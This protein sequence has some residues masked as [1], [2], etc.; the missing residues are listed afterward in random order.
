MAFIP[1]FILEQYN[2]NKKWFVNWES[3]SVLK[4][5]FIAL[6]TL[7]FKTQCCVAGEVLRKLKL[8]T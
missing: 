8:I 3:K 1:A 5:E 4:P 2:V 7:S 6:C